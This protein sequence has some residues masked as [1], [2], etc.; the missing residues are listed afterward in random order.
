MHALY[1]TMLQLAFTVQLSSIFFTSMVWRTSEDFKPHFTAPFPT[2]PRW[3]STI[4]HLVPRSKIWHSTNWANQTHLLTRAIHFTTGIEEDTQGYLKQMW[5]KY[6]FSDVQCIHLSTPLLP[7]SQ[8]TV[9][10]KEHLA[11]APV[12]CRLI[13]WRVIAIRWPLAVITSHSS[14]RWR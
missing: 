12:S 2:D 8:L 10:S 5:W 6:N 4:H 9:S 14:A 3:D 1:S 7:H 13:P 11:S